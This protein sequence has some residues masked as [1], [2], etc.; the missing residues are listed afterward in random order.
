MTAY[1]SSDLTTAQRQ[2]VEHMTGPL[3]VL[4]G[5]GSG[6]TRVIT[7]RIARLVERGIDSRRILAIT[8]T[9]K[10]ASEMGE[11]V[12]ALL[13]GC[14][15]QVSTFHKFC[16]RLLRQRA[17]MVGLRSNYS[18][19]DT[20]DQKSLIRR[21]FRDLDIDA[22]ICSPARIA[23]RISRAKNDLMSADEFSRQFRESIGDHIQAIT[24]RVY[25]EYQRR[26]FASNAVDFDDLLLYVVDLLSN[27]PELRRY[28]DERYQYVLVDEYQD[29]NAAQYRIVT[30]LSQTHS[31]L[32]ATGDPDQSIYGWRGARIDNILRFERD[33]PQTTVIRLEENFRS[34]G[35]I[36]RA[37]DSLIAH[38]V[39]R[40]AKSL[41]TDN[42]L[43]EPVELRR[44]RDAE[45]EADE[46][47]REIRAA[48]DAGSR[49]YRDFAVFYRV[50]ALS[51]EI[52][53]AMSRHHV[54]FQVAAGTAFYERAEVKDLLAYLQL[55]H[56]PDNQAAFL[57]IVN[58]PRR[59]IGRV[60]VNRLTAWASLRNV[61]LPEAAVRATEIPELSK[62][63]ARKLVQ[64]ASMLE[65]FRR[66]PVDSIKDLLTTVIE[67]TGYGAEWADSESE[68]DRQRLANVGELV[69][70]TGQY[71][72]LSEES[73]SLEGFLETTS[74]TSDI[75]GLDETAG[76]VT[77]MTLHAAKGLEF[78]VVYTIAV[79]RD[80]I[81]HA[82][83][84]GGNDLSQVEEE[85]RLLFVGITRARERL[86]LTHT[87]ERSIRGQSASSIPSSFLSE[88]R[89]VHRDLTTVAADE[90]TGENRADASGKNPSGPAT[91]SDA[92]PRLTT[93]ADLL[94]GNAREAE[95]PRG[96]SVGMTVRH[97]QDGLGTVVETGGFSRRRTVTVE[98]CD[99]GQTRTFVVSLCPL[100]PVGN[101]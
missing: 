96:F 50:N 8:F 37:A 64:F 2:V 17:E 93:A 33:F 87:A 6:K 12:A 39:H 13:P 48:V 99:T 78:P 81:P 51:R 45:H 62:R 23:A 73:G 100:Q 94:N 74:L 95:L 19:Y 43:G 3:L 44:Y 75:D 92:R 16:A 32:C 14:A 63:T 98:F 5:P 60:T 58:V 88:M 79:E 4:A 7:R 42:P 82:R 67:R 65:E 72:Q 15:V 101:R 9:N 59:G 11:R 71:D 61:N 69:T 25:P 26:L 49:P 52:E 77:L 66:L 97:P 56:N 46:I 68:L 27:N 57:R 30:A 89:L 41:V 47:A 84:L 1:D 20:T 80:L 29:T 70:A 24:A 28:Y 83:A 53:R 31:N 85:R 36:L 40:K 90:F 55:V 10:A 18:I 22:K 76:T 91:S 34:T 54:P 35:H 21:I 86:I 38:N